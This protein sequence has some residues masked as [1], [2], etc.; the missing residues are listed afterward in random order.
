MREKSHHLI[1]DAR[2]RT[3]RERFFT[4]HFTVNVNV[5]IF[6]NHLV[7]V[8]EMC[9]VGIGIVCTGA[10]TIHICVRCDRCEH[11]PMFTDD[12]RMSWLIREHYYYLLDIRYHLKRDGVVR[13]A[14]WFLYQTYASL[15]TLRLVS[16][17]THMLIDRGTMTPSSRAY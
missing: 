12:G 8:C 7:C 3:A 11:Q 13:L 14:L 15:L 1:F 2:T 16:T 17:R 5:L 4:L 9:S 10:Y 6:S